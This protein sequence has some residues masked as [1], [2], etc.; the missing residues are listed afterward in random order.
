MNRKDRFIYKKILP[1]FTNFFDKYLF[2]SFEE[3]RTNIYHEYNVNDYRADK[4]KVILIH[5]PKTGGLSIWKLLENENV[6]FNFNKKS[7]HNPVSLLCQPKDYKYITFLR[8]PISRVYSYYHMALKVKWS[9]DHFHAKKSL[10]MFLQNCISAKNLSCQYF[11]G[12]I[13]ENVDENIYNLAK[14]NLKNFYFV[15]L[16]E[17]FNNDCL[18]LIKLLDLKNKNIIIP[19]IK[20]TS[21]ENITDEEKLLIKTYNYYDIKL[22]ENFLNEYKN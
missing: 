9:P 22:Y 6:L 19:K 3:R 8:N 14:Q 1:L 4:N 7:R 15:G 20:P 13:R 16:F 17:N 11:S 10:A 2:T 18:K 12:L 5:V 21:Y